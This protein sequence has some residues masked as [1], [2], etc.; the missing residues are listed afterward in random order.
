MSLTHSTSEGG[1]LFFT[2]SET[3][4]HCHGIVRKLTFR[5][6]RPFDGTTNIKQKFVV[7]YLR[8]C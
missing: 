2:V 6:F 4:N 8:H 3:I 1:M 5:L 7:T